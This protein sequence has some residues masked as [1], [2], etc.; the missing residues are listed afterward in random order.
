MRILFLFISFSF[1]A[2][3]FFALN[4]PISIVQKKSVSQTERGLE[5]RYIILTDKI[6]KE[7]NEIVIDSVKYFL[8]KTK[9]SAIE[10]IKY[11]NQ[12]KDYIIVYV[13]TEKKKNT[14]IIAIPSE[15][16]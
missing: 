12:K 10:S 14:E 5:I 4:A 7:K 16:N 11:S 6:A 1:S 3:Y 15:N 13:L 8:F 2:I 9:E